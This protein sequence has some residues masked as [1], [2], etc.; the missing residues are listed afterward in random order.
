MRYS[1]AALPT[2]PV[3]V[4]VK[5]PST[6]SVALAPDSVYV[7]SVSSVMDPLPMS[8]TTGAVVSATVTVRSNEAT[9]PAL[10]VAV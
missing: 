9:L 1:P 2:E 5:T 10:S 7:A 3:I 6:L 4:T 8:V